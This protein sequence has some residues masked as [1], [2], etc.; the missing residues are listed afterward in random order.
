M[1]PIIVAAA[2]PM[3]ISLLKDSLEGGGRFKAGHREIYEGKIAGS[4]VILAAT[5]IGKVNAASAVTAVLE[6]YESELLI[7][8]GCAGAYAGGG[9]AVG[10]LAMATV[11]VFGDEGVIAPDGW[12][13]MEEIGIPTLSR[14]GNDY[15][16]HFPMTRWA[17][18]KAGHVAERNGTPLHQG[19][20][21]T[22]STASGTSDRGAELFQ[23]FGAVCEN[24]E[25]AAVAQ[26]AAFYGV[27]CMEVR[28]VS[29]LVE[30]RDLSRWD[31]PLAV[32]R[33]QKFVM[34]F[35]EALCR[36]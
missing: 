24:M 23:R 29:N 14:K 19:V 32:E 25:G 13:S 27:D 16:N 20:F 5:G 18:D 33:A 17:I 35:I 10:D 6:H 8:T 1:K 34:D 31:I 3:E 21:V 30:D 2:T 26:V 4:S 11:E 15:Y 12:H 9:L 28:G 7:N 22:L 36:I